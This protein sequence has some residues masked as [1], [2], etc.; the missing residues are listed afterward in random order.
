MMGLGDLEERVR[1]A[2]ADLVA[3]RQGISH[4]GRELAGL[5]T[6]L[7]ELREDLAPMLAAGRAMAEIQSG[8]GLDLAGMMAELGGGE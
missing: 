8:G 5:R 7:A 4:V 1:R 2:E 3:I 6:E